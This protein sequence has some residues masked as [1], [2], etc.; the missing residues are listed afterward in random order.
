VVL[1]SGNTLTLDLRF[2]FDLFDRVDY[3]FVAPCSRLDT[4]HALLAQSAV[5]EP[6]DFHSDLRRTIATTWQLAVGSW[7]LEVGTRVLT[8]DSRKPLLWCT[9]SGGR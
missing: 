1:V 8:S 5:I 9:T 7:K 3:P 4:A 2:S 6:N